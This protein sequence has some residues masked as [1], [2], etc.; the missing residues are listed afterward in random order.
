MNDGT[1]GLAQ[2]IR[3]EDDRP[4]T[5]LLVAGT[6]RRA[7]GWLR[8]VPILDLL[9]DWQVHR[10]ALTALDPEDWAPVPDARLLAPITYPRKLLCAGANYYEHARE[11]GTA[12]PDPAEA[13]FF[14]LKPPTTTIRAHG[15][16]VAYP[17]RHDVQLDWEA[18]LAVVIGRT[19]KDIEAAD[20]SAYIAGYSAANDLSARGS[21]VRPNPVMAPFAYDWLGHK[22]R[23]GSCPLG[24][25]LVPEWLIPDPQNL[26]IS[27][28]VNG[29]TKQKSTT[30]DMVVDVAGLVA[31]ASWMVTLEPGDVL[32]TGTPAGVGL[33]REEF[34]RPGDVVTLRIDRIGELTTHIGPPVGPALTTPTFR[35]TGLN[36]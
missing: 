3:A 5:G 14:F 1:W 17:A 34:L 24:P 33:P 27:L 29:A 12:R 31:A 9:D 8:S 16:T 26:P 32:L 22:A 18:E 10:P 21:F 20:A 7:P 13:P 4:E 2:F 36:P 25:A 15:A 23:D 28:T 35:E 6:V 30:A 11:M 19:A